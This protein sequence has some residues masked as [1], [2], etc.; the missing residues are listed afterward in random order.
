MNVEK[1][2]ISLSSGWGSKELVLISEKFATDMNI[3]LLDHDMFRPVSCQWV[4]FRISICE[5]LLHQVQERLW[6]KVQFIWN[7]SDWPCNMEIPTYSNDWEFIANLH[8]LLQAEETGT[9]DQ[10]CSLFDARHLDW[11]RRQRCVV[12]RSIIHIFGLAWQRGPTQ[13]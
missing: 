7:G 11:Q 6:H 13:F 9:A 5:V 8:M 12:C 2:S 1:E 10:G 4:S 3:Q